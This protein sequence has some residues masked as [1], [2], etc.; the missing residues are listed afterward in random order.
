M[1]QDFHHADQEPLLADWAVRPHER[2]Q[3]RAGEASA[4]LAQ[5]PQAGVAVEDRI[6]RLQRPALVEDDL[7]L[8][9]PLR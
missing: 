1:P 4:Q 9:R 8:E 7:V 3:Q 2:V 6:D 5:L